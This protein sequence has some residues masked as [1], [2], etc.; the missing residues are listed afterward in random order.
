MVYI[1]VKEL[2]LDCSAM[3]DY[4]EISKILEHMKSQGVQRDEIFVSEG[5]HACTYQHS[6]YQAVCVC[7]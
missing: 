7:F 2:P 1:L 3:P 4:D 6:K 5:A